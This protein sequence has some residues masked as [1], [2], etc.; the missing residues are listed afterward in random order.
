MLLL[1]IQIRPPDTYSS[2]EETVLKG[3]IVP[4]MVGTIH[5]RSW[6]DKGEFCVHGQCPTSKALLTTKLYFPPPRPSLVPR[7][8]LVER[9]LGDWRNLLRSA[10]VPSFV[11]GSP[12]NM[13]YSITAELIPSAN[14]LAIGTVFWEILA[15]I[16]HILFRRTHPKLPA[17]MRFES[18]DPT[19]KD[20]RFPAVPFIA[21]AIPGLIII[22]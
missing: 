22:L 8:R 18:P 10:G 11:P 2:P 20:L 9:M 3:T 15:V 14:A 12:Y 5:N 19:W 7:P 17:G 13:G 16:Y 21:R 4:R 6:Y 1:P